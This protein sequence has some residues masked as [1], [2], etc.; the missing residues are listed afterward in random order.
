MFSC[1]EL[2]GNPFVCNCHLA[3]L[4]EWLRAGGVG[5]VA[6]QCAAP[7]HLS[8]SPL[9]DIPPTEFKCASGADAGCLG[10]DYCPPAC[11]CAGTVVRCSRANLTEVPSGLP[12][13]TSELYLDVNRIREL[14]PDRLKHLKHLTRLYAC[15]EKGRGSI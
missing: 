2:G 4:S 6:A 1:S 14:Q 13:E 8:G 15:V 10:D 12:P 11:A 7:A 9:A 3:W 5:G